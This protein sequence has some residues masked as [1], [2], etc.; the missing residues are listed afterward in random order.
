M[1]NITVSVDEETYQRARVRAAQEGTSVS[2]LVRSILATLGQCPG[3]ETEFER[4]KRLQEETL[5]RIVARGAGLR[6]RD[7]VRREAL[8]ERHAVR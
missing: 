6:S 2:A 8:H 4:L 7:N 1:K 3:A 5:A